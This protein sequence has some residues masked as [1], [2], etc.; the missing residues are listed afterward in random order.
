MSAEEQMADGVNCDRAP[1]ERA[2]EEIAFLEYRGVA[3]TPPPSSLWPW[4][5]P[6]GGARGPSPGGDFQ[7]GRVA[8]PP[9]ALGPD[10]M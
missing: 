4:P 7:G 1:P 9:G 6:W 3:L 2:V 10:G 8:D 5:G